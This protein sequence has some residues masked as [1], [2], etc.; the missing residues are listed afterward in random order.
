MK[1][2]YGTTEP[3]GLVQSSA[4][5]IN[6]GVELFN[7]GQKFEDGSTK[8]GGYMK[9][10][11]GSSVS[12]LVSDIESSDT[13][14]QTWTPLAEAF[15]EA[16]R[17][18]RK[19][20]S[21]YNSG[22][23]YSANDPIT[24]NCMKN[25]IVILTDGQATKDQNL[26][27][28]SF[29]GTEV[30]EASGTLAKYQFGVQNWINF[31]GTKES[32]P[33][34]YTTALGSDGS[35][36]LPAV[37]FWAHTTDLR[38]DRSGMQNLTTYVVYTF[39]DD[40]TARNILIKTA[41]YGGFDDLNIAD[42]ATVG[43]YWPDSTSKWD[44][45][46]DGVPD[47]YFE[48]QNG[49][50]LYASIKSAFDDI[51]SKVSSGTSA[52]IVNNRGESG[53][54]LFQA[55]FYPK[56]TAG[57]SELYWI[58]ELQNMWYY[59]DPLISTSSIREDTDIN[60]K[61]DLK[62]D[63]MVS[64]E[65]DTN[66]NQTVSTWYKDTTGT[67]SYTLDTSR[68]SGSPDGIRALWRAGG[69]LHLRDPATRTIYSS[70]SNYNGSLMNGSTAVSAGSSG[71]TGFS[72]TYGATLLPYMNVTDTATANKVVN[73]V[74]GVDYPGDKT[75]RLRTTTIAYPASNHAP[76][77]AAITGVWKLGDVVSSTPQ[78]ET[79]K[80]LQNYDV[81]YKDTSYYSFYN[82]TDY[83]NRDT[84]FAASNDGMLHAFRVGK[85]SKT[86]Y[87]AI[88][89]N[90]IAQIANTPSS[91][92][93]TLDLGDEEWGFVPMNVLPYL[94][95]YG[96]P[97]YNHLYYVNNTV[98][99]L[100]ASINR[101]SNDTTSCTQA[102]YW[103]CTKQTT[104]QSSTKN[105]SED[106]TSWRTILI[107][108]MG[109]GGASR[110]YTGFCN[111]ADGSTP[112]NLAAE[113]TSGRLDCVKSPMTGVGLSSFFA[114]DVTKPRAPKFLWEFS[115]AALPA[116][117]RGLGYSTSGPA[118][119]RMSAKQDTGQTTGSPDTTKNGRWFGVFATGP[120]GKIDTSSHQFLGRS[121]NNLK[122]YVVD[123]HPD[124][125]SGWV[126]NTNYWV[127]DSGL[128]NSFAG[129][130]SDVVVDVDRWNSSAEGHYSD[131]VVYI[132]YTSPDNPTA[133]TSWTN[134]GV[135]RLLTNNSTEPSQWSLSKL[136][137]N[138]GPVTSS[139]SKLQDRKNG[140]L[141]VFFGTGRY[142]FKDNTGV[143]D[144]TSQ[145]YLLGVQDT[146][147]DG[148]KNTMNSGYI[149]GTAYGCAETAPTVLGLSDLQNQTSTIIQTLPS[150]KK[151]WYIGLDL[152]GSYAMGAD[153][154]T[155]TYDAE[156]VVTNT[157]ANFNGT[158]FYTT[159]KPTSDICGYGGSTLVWIIDY[160]NGGVPPSS[161]LKGKLLV[162]LSSGE[163]AAIDL[164]SA[165]KA[166][167][168][169]TQATRG[170]RR[171]KAS[172][173]GHGLAG[174]KGGSLQSAS[175]P[176]RKILHIMEK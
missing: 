135:L 65:Y 16:T 127:F 136:I 147:Y 15:Y 51:V 108:G 111:K 70:V 161:T 155:A 103:N 102:T 96:D 169:A 138:V 140:K 172:L 59:L 39:D 128:K 68:P 117:D 119:V 89:P 44:K 145:R 82:S 9:S 175:Q 84:V 10:L 30:T 33:N 131:N 36:Y 143:D 49:D 95:Y 153:M 173:A 29:T 42:S 134:G 24:A 6:F 64:V 32:L 162:Q 81:S 146:C 17:Y 3:T 76:L 129:D 144:P 54:N 149:S 151:G 113:T 60:R 35:W 132:G 124:L 125:T 55:V 101:P 167:G 26:P 157:M 47:T 11:L 160:L 105:L 93:D 61:L 118:I 112:A 159:F 56:K 121:D 116:A 168:D 141:W 122:V 58:G 34:L 23:T 48:A 165:T 28:G 99:I 27:G 91:G 45:N 106:N 66:T 43:T 164:S 22:V 154:T 87:S 38:T 63:D 156:R 98:T 41:K 176:V 25:F 126:K 85:V 50:Q 115:D 171:M 86:A 150:T 18:F 166:N 69:M 130:L 114:L 73:Y 139:P 133:P 52:S 90:T 57:S 94:K 7:E 46:G 92:T 80:Q 72:D 53:S 137:D 110:D 104:Y 79:S 78:A 107:G 83:N 1:I 2:L 40:A 120:S 148:V 152:Q 19:E 8:D 12:T 37:A 123:L 142:Y 100:D 97:A 75:Y 88:T 5:S 74:R 62:A 21:A 77:N 67:G 174:S 14:P 71:F 158:V 109:L 163:F 170:D 20:S 13:D 4:D 31:I